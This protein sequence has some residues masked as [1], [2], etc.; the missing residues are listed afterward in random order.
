V[1][2]QSRNRVVVDVDAHGRVALGRLEFK[3]TQV[4]VDQLQGGGSVIHE[5]VVLTPPEAATMPIRRPS[6]A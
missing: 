4:V 5:A 1:N 2:D 3:S 6:I